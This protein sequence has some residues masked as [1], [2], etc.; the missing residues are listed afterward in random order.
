MEKIIL[1]NERKIE[2][3]PGSFFGAVTVVVNDFAELSSIAE[4]ITKPENV[5]NSKVFIWRHHY[6]NTYWHETGKSGF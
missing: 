3:A 5:G 6:R 1:K 2:I 4:D